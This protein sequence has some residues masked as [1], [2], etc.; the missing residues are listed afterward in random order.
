MNLRKLIAPI[1]VVVLLVHCFLLW[2][3]QLE[4]ARI[5]KILLMPLLLLYLAEALA[6]S[7]IKLKLSTRL[8]ALAFLASWG[9]D[10]FLL[11]TG[12]LFFIGGMLCFILAHFCYIILFINIQPFKISN[13]FLPI[14]GGI[15]VLVM[16]AIILNHLAP[17]LGDLFL[18]VLVYMIV[19]ATM[20]S[21]SI[22][23]SCNAGT[24]QF[25]INY[26][27]P[28]AALFVLSDSVLS[29]NI[30]AYKNVFLGVIVMLTYGFAQFLLAKGFKNYLLTKPTV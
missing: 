24:K 5:T 12:N 17:K 21:S 3:E 7:T 11:Y 10:I 13:A 20:F 30:F 23:I 25:G 4:M 14:M 15:V 16:G 18:P 9:G 27:V 19:I 2:S 8:V 29:L 1:Y 6:P 22:L 26:F 28:G